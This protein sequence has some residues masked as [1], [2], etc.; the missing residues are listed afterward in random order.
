MYA[1]AALYNQASNFSDTSYLSHKSENNVILLLRALFSL[2]C[3]LINT[4]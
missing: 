4:C 1:W 2:P 3:N